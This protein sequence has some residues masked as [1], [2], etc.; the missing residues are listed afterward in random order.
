MSYP[1]TPPFKDLTP[2][3]REAMIETSAKRRREE[4][5]EQR[6]PMAPDH[7]LTWENTNFK[8]FDNE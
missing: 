5:A 7:D 4:L 2:A 8:G 1:N 3:Q 6:R